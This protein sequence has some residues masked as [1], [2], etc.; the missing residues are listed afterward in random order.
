MRHLSAIENRSR[1]CSWVLLFYVISISLSVACTET[2]YTNIALEIKVC[3]K[4]AGIATLSTV[5]LQYF[6]P[7]F[8]TACD[9]NR[10]MK[11]LPCSIRVSIG[12]CVHWL[13]TCQF[14]ARHGEVFKNK[15]LSVQS[16]VLASILKIRKKERGITFWNVY[17]YNKN[18]ECA[19]HTVG[20]GREEA[21]K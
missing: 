11:L 21:V 17:K 4:V 15:L 6:P 16:N 9:F 5:M 14:S 20:M 19:A 12:M 13:G 10:S 7:I 18:I 1:C 2:L 8:H 3:H